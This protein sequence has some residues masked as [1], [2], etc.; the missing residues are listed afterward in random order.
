MRLGLQ[1]ELRKAGAEL[2]AEAAVARKRLL[3]E[4]LSE[5]KIKAGEDEWEAAL[6]KANPKGILSLKRFLPTSLPS[7]VGA[8]WRREGVV[9]GRRVGRRWRRRRG[10]RARPKSQIPRV[11]LVARRRRPKSTSDRVGFCCGV[12][13][14]PVRDIFWCFPAVGEFSPITASA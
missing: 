11:S 5:Y 9:E 13:V 3:E 1:A 12:Y 6:S 14:F 4:N 7:P 8:E 10:P 2:E